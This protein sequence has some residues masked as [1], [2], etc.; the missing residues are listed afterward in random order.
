M[1]YYDGNNVRFDN[2]APCLIKGKGSIKLTKKI[3]FENAYYVEG[4]NY[5]L[6]SVSQLNKLGCKVEFENK[7]AKI[8]DASG[9]LIGK[10][11]QTRSNLFY[12]DID[13]VTCLVAKFNDTWLWHKILC[14]VNLDNLIRISHIKRVRGLPKLKKLENT[15]YKQCQLGNMTKSS[16]KIKAHT[17]KEI[18]EIVHIDL[19]GPM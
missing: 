11:D 7:T 16:F 13:D 19:C 18:L 5:N 2:D 10:G 14:H 17:S 6:L 4:L 1:N 9:K 15:V 8:Y 12:L 3:L